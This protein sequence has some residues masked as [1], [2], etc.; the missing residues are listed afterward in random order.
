MGR[1]RE[2]RERRTFIGKSSEVAESHITRH[3][4]GAVGEFDSDDRIAAHRARR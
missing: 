4:G 3:R 2:P 1:D